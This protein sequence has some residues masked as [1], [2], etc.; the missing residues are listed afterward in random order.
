MKVSHAAADTADAT[1]GMAVRAGA[2][3]RRIDSIVLRSFREGRQDS[4]ALLSR[5]D[6]VR[7]NDDHWTGDGSRPDEPR[8]MV[9]AP[10]RTIGVAISN[11]ALAR[12]TQSS[13]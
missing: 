2:N 13:R 10:R 12:E 11:A 1:V 7:Q 4:L 9:E 6:A 5:G 8:D 3:A